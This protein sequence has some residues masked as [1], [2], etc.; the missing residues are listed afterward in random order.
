MSGAHDSRV[1]TLLRLD[2][3]PRE[4]QQQST[5]SF[6]RTPVGE[7][8]RPRFAIGQPQAQR[9]DERRHGGWGSSQVVDEHVVGNLN[10]DGI[11]ARPC[12]RPTKTG[13]LRAKAQFAEWA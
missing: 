13:F 7:H 10:D 3:L 4:L 6:L 2:A 9:A 1:G 12:K 8:L 5:E 11:C